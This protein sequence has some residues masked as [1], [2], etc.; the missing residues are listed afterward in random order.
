[1][2]CP[3]ERIG[4]FMSHGENERRENEEEYQLNPS[5][6]WAGLPAFFLHF[7]YNRWGNG[8]I[9]MQATQLSETDLITPNRTTHDSACHLLLHMLDTEW[10]WRIVCQE[11]VKTP[12]LWEVEKIPDLN[13]LVSCWQGEAER[14]DAYLKSLKDGDLSREIDYG[15]I[16]S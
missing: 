5:P 15:S 8:R 10:S 12:L 4:S 13:A 3:G 11:G 6:V 16:L 2:R 9:L 7:G 14:M 1:R